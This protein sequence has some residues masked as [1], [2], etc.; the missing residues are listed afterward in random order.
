VI[1]RRLTIVCT[2]ACAGPVGPGVAQVV[3][4]AQSADTLVLSLSRAEALA[5][6]NHPFV[7]S[8]RVDLQ[9]AEARRTR[10]R[11]S[12]WVPELRLSNVWGPIPDARGE[13]TEFGVLVSPDSVDAINNL[14]WFTQTSLELVQPLY[15]FGRIDRLVGAAEA[16]VEASAA[17]VEA[18]SD[19]VRLQVRK[20]YWAMVLGEQ[21]VDVADEV[22]REIE[23]A[24]VQLQERYEDGSV[25]QN[26]LFEFEIYRFRAQK[27][28]REAVDGLEMA[29]AALRAAAGIQDGVPIRAE[30]PELTRLAVNLDSLAGYLH[31]ARE[32]RPELAQLRAGIAAQSSLA[33]ATRSEYYPQ[34][35]LAGAVEWNHAP[36]RF[37]PR[38]PFV[39]NP[40]NFFRPGVVL[41]FDWNVNLFQTRDRVRIA[42]HEAAKLSAQL[43]PLAEKIQLDVREAY[44]GLVRA[45]A[46]VEDSERALTAADNWF[47]AESQTFDLGIGE[48][49]DLVDAFQAKIEMEREHL[50]SIF[51]FNTALADLSRAVGRDLYPN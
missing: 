36:G 48:I 38:N 45:A 8:A 12:R 16:G 21:L 34:L 13:I 11:H 31:M 26:D 44:L 27:G 22:L 40:T 15:T 50:Q 47:R 9:L 3:Q 4:P 25:S 30:T 51:D 41:G 29:R 35:F 2:L 20:A 28:R 23:E 10:A 32:G 6:D 14:G 49:Q 33:R 37:D 18:T 24:D 17:G 46:N 42:E 7:S 19:E 1:A 5:L 43:S 39:Y